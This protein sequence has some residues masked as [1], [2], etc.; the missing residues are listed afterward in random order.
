ME[1]FDYTQPEGQSTAKFENSKYFNQDNVIVQTDYIL[2]SLS[3]PEFGLM[4]NDFKFTLI[5]D[6]NWIDEDL[7]KIKKFLKNK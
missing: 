1:M 5:E 2:D 6:M 7:P 4:F 3:A